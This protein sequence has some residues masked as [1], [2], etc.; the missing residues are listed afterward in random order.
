MDAREVLVII[1]GAHKVKG[2]NS[3]PD[4]TDIKLAID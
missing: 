1:T 2:V 3:I 4:V